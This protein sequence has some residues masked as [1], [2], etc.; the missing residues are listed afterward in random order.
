MVTL[1]PWLQHSHSDIDHV[2]PPLPQVGYDMTKK[3]ADAVYRKSGL[4]PQDV[5]VVELHDCFSTNE[6]ITYEALSLCSPGER[7]R[8]GGMSIKPRLP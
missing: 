3:A 2:C 4:G 6:L 8:G 1:S 5:Q 7:E